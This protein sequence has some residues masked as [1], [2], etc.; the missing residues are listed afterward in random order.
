MISAEGQEGVSLPDK[1]APPRL[2]VHA[3]P[4][5]LNR[6]LHSKGVDLLLGSS[7]R[8]PGSVVPNNPED[9]A[10]RLTREISTEHGLVAARMTWN[11]TFQGFLFAAYALG[12]SRA[13]QEPQ[14]ALLLRTLPIAGAVTAGLTFIG[15]VAA[16]ARI[17]GL[18]RDWY[19]NQP[20]FERFRPR[21]F[22]HPV[23]GFFG[24]VPPFGITFV[25]LWCW[26]SLRWPHGW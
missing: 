3:G 19:S 18:K 1:A 25:L 7:A 11:L 15:I 22:S 5:W 2:P 23:G 12:S 10:E 6:L 9:Y 17:N 4:A 24:R 8:P 20:E 16:W 13:G 14:V 26:T 21:P